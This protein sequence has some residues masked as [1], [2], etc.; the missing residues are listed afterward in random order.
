[1]PADAVGLWK[2][3]LGGPLSAPVVAAGLVLVARTDAHELCA[4]DARTGDIRWRHT[5]D[6]PVDSPPTMHAGTALF[7]TR[8]GRVTCLRADDGTVVWRFR[9]SPRERLVNAFGQ[10]ESAWPTSGSVLVSGDRAFFAAGR[11][12]ELDGGIHV[13]AVEP[14]TGKVLWRTQTTNCLSEILT[15][16]VYEKSYPPVVLNDVLASSGGAVSMGTLGFDVETGKPMPRTYTL[17]ARSGMLDDGS[18]VGR[19]QWRGPR[20]HANL[21]VFDGKTTCGF[22]LKPTTEW[23]VIPGQ[24][25]YVLFAKSSW[26]E[27][28]WARRT[29]L[30]AV[31]MIRAGE[32][33][34]LA[35]VPDAVD[36]K[37]YWAAVR[38]RKG[39][40][41][42]FVSLADGTKTAGMRLEVPP[43][44]D[45]MAAAGGRLYLATTDGKVH[46]LGAR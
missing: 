40:E 38:G 36:E 37:D 23:P 5:T 12:S 25:Q 20:A 11:F 8:T 33:L 17:W 16:K 24:G 7:G 2:T 27:T 34:L 29:V 30:R 1:V 28:L 45:G 14:A 22:A 4:L 26:K 15:G 31:A 44:F 21:L 43:V 32:S 9:A 39:A 19:M 46:C 18:W 41:L 3:E 35:G 42:H 6:G 10:L 13:Y